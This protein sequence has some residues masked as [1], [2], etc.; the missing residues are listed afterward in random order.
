MWV[1]I[2]YIIVYNRILMEL[3]DYMYIEAF[4]EQVPI[5]NI[6]ELQKLKSIILPIR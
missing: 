6:F 2:K 1:E 4:T 5:F 3:F